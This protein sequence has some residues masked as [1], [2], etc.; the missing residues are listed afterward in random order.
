M[1]S[2]SGAHCH[3]LIAKTAQDMTR[4]LYEATMQNDTLFTEW[5]RQH[6]GMSGSGLENAFV[7]K[8]WPAAI[9][10]A[11][12]TLAHMLTLPGDEGLKETIAEALILDKSLIKGRKD[13]VQMLN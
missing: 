3:L 11:R 8:Y 10:G 2:K 6:P 9:D 1:K 13:N 4:A 5:K 7:K 12:A